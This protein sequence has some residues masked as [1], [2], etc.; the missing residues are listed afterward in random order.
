MTFSQELGA[1][2]DINC[3]QPAGASST[4]S[5][6]GDPMQASTVLTLKERKVNQ[7]QD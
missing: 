1:F 3:T 7:G 5:S 4:E 2:T 6:V